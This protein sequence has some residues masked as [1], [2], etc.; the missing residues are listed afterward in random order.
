[1]TEITVEQQQ[2]VLHNILPIFELVDH[3]AAVA[4]GCAR[5]WFFGQ[6]AKDIDVFMH[7]QKG[8]VI[9]RDI[10]PNLSRIL[11]VDFKEKKNSSS[12]SEGGSKKLMD[13][14]VSVWSATIDDVDF[15]LVFVENSLKD[16]SSVLQ[17]FDLDICKIEYDADTGMP[18]PTKQFMRAVKSKTIEFPFGTDPDSKRVSRMKEKFPDYK[19]VFLK[20]DKSVKQFKKFSGTRNFTAHSTKVVSF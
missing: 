3:T 1:M 9:K 4:G 5:D 17:E 14:L 2:T 19:I 20:E 13:S 8:R 15:D 12:L 10:I 7:P 11:G 18:I 16:T 6:P